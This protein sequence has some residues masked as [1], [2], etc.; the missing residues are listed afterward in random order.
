MICLCLMATLICK[1]QK[2]NARADTI[3]RADVKLYSDHAKKDLSTLDRFLLIAKSTVQ[4]SFVAPNKDT[5]LIEFNPP[6]WAPIP[7][8]LLPRVAQIYYQTLSIAMTRDSMKYKVIGIQICN[9]PTNCFTTWFPMQTH[10]W[11]LKLTFKQK[12]GIFLSANFWP[13]D[14][15][16]R[17]TTNGKALVIHYFIDSTNLFSQLDYVESFFQSSSTIIAD[18]I[19]K[20]KS[21]WAKELKELIVIF[22]RN[23][24]LAYFWRFPIIPEQMSKIY[25]IKFFERTRR[26]LAY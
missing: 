18:L 13:C 2:Q 5:L 7:D 11:N 9:D 23:G 19:Y 25:K 16:A 3:I 21:K 8:S 1:G 10:K 14:A 20:S 6:T 12:L 17:E 4:H 24:S 22:C 15:Q 26:L